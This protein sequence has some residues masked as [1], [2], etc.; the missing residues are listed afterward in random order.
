[1]KLTYLELQTIKNFNEDL[2]WKYWALEADLDQGYSYVH[3]GLLNEISNHIRKD[4]RY[5]QRHL[6][7]HLSRRD[8]LASHIK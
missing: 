4:Q 3:F 8:R 5:Y 1:M 6:C 7:S 2:Y